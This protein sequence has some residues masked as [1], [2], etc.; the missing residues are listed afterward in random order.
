MVN[1]SK[2]R[3]SLADATCLTLKWSRRGSAAS[4]PARSDGFHTP[5]IST[6]AA[7]A[8]AGS[9]TPPDANATSPP[10]A[11]GRDV[12]H[13]AAHM[14]SPELSARGAGD[15]PAPA[16]WLDADT[17][18][19]PEPGSDSAGPPEP[20]LCVETGCEPEPEPEPEPEEERPLSPSWSPGGGFGTYFSLSALVQ[21]ATLRAS[22]PDWG[23]CVQ[24]G[25]GAPGFK[26]MHAH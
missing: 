7:A 21:Q 11:D 13:E 10:K 14:D 6:P 17:L 19:E 15:N 5:G 22:A 3:L 16:A 2:L 26:A 4:E 25:G 9:G 24:G 12:G 8:P 1:R 18:G 23:P 20:E